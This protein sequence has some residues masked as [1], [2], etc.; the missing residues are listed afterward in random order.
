M[1]ATDKQYKTLTPLIFLRREGMCPIQGHLDTQGLSAVS[2]FDEQ[3][4][5]SVKGFVLDAVDTARPR[6]QQT[7]VSGRSGSESRPESAPHLSF[8]V[9]G[10]GST[11]SLLHVQPLAPAGFLTVI[12]GTQGGNSF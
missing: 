3:L 11:Q 4:Q 10:W 6:P 8:K 5:G 9:R 7:P 1:S 12:S 2:T